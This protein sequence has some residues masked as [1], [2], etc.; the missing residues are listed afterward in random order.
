[1]SKLVVYGG[2]GWLGQWLRDDLEE[3]FDSVDYSRDRVSRTVPTLPD[4]TTHVLC[5]IGRTRGGRVN[6]I[7][8]LQGRVDENVHDNLCAPLMLAEACRRANAHMT[9]FGT[10][11]LFQEDRVYTEDDTPNF[12]DSEYCLV[13]GYTDSLMRAQ[14]HVLNVRFRMP[15]TDGH[16]PHCYVRKLIQYGAGPGILSRPNSISVLP[17]LLP[18]L[19]EAMVTRRT[20][21]MHWL[22]RGTITHRRVL[23]LYREIVDPTYEWTEQTHDPRALSMTYRQ[24][25]ESSGKDPDTYLEGDGPSVTIRPSRSN[26]SVKADGPDVETAVRQLFEDNF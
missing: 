4:G 21:T 15:V 18:M 24:V 10:A 25:L 7:D 20:G 26:V 13:K 1:M 12:K 14:E 3:W 23:E 22:N 6:H 9:Y 5:L 19:H 2:F 16:S 17:S 11:C 8:Y